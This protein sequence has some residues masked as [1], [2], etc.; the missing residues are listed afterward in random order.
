MMRSVT[1]N[2]DVAAPIEL[3][4]P[5]FDAQHE[6]EWAPDWR[7]TPREPQPFR[8]IRNAVFEVP[9][10]AAFEDPQAQSPEL[11]VVLEFDA[12]AHRV[13]YLAVHG[14]HFVRRVTVTCQPH[15]RETRVSVRYDLTALDAD[16]QAKLSH[17]DDS[18]L[19]S[20]ERPVRDAARRRLGAAQ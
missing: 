12:G 18:Y 4:F 15:G 9:H 13:E 3:V 19:A 2:F 17:F 6:A 11:W 14:R 7:Y 10:N 1:H 16:G 8:T 20:W 5:L